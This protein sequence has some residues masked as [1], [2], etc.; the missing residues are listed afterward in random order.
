MEERLPGPS[1]SNP[2][3]CAINSFPHKEFRDK[4]EVFKGYLVSL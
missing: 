3:R 2:Y 1:Q 4:E